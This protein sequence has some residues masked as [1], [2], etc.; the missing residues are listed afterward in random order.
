[1]ELDLE[2]LQ[3]TLPSKPTLTA[4]KGLARYVAEVLEVCPEA[5][6]KKLQM[7]FEESAGQKKLSVGTLCSGSDAVIDV[8]EASFFA[9]L[10][11]SKTTEHNEY[12]VGCFPVAS[13]TKQVSNAKC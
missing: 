13:Q 12:L 4:Q 2:D 11:M 5:Y 1:M 7:L 3:D 8:L 6:A 10:C 9:N